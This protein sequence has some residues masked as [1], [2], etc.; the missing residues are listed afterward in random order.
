MDVRKKTLVPMRI[1]IP[2]PSSL[3]GWQGS[4]SQR[5]EWSREDGIEFGLSISVQS[6]PLEH[7]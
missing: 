5:R 7:R 6:N 4:Q 3:Q 2:M 1:S